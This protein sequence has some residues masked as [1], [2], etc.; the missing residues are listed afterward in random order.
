MMTGN[1]EA[2]SKVKLVGPVAYDTGVQV[3]LLAAILFSMLF[4]PIDKSFP[5]AAG[6]V[7]LTGDEVIDIDMF[8]LGK[9]LPKQK[10]G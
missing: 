2:F 10:T 8:R 5:C 7:C 9:L 6:A 3:K 4:E 1:I